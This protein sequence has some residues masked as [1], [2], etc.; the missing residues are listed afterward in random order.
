MH[1]TFLTLLLTLVGTMPDEKPFVITHVNL[2]DCVG[3]EPL[4]DHSVIIS[5]NRITRIGPSK[6]VPVPPNATVVDG[7]GKY[8]I[9]GLWDMHIHWYGKEQIPL[10]IANG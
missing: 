3:T 4:A 1:A 2:I 9:P 7:Q 8:L 10:F 5:G 6:D